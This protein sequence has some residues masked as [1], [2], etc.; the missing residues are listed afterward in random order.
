MQKLQPKLSR[1]LSYSIFAVVVSCVTLPRPIQLPPPASIPT[2][3]PTELRIGKVDVQGEWIRLTPEQASKLAVQVKFLQEL[4][5]ES[6]LLGR[7]EGEIALDASSSI[8]QQMHRRYM[9]Q[10]LYGIAGAFVLGTAVGI[11]ITQDKQ[12]E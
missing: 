7:K 9:K 10:F 4:V 3:I 11:V 12:N 2:S 1:I 8:S 5:G 6:Y